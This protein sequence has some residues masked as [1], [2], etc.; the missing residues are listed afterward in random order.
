MD[1]HNQGRASLTHCIRMHIP[2]GSMRYQPDSQDCIAWRQTKSQLPS[3][4]GLRSTG[5]EQMNRSC[6]RHHSHPG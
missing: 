4:V 6:S 3:R 5:A 1:T 2:K